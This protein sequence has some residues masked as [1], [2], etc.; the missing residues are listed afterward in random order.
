MNL[1]NPPWVTKDARPGMELAS[2]GGFGGPSEIALRGRAVLA[3]AGGMGFEQ[4]RRF[5]ASVEDYGLT[6]VQAEILALTAQGLTNFEVAKRRG[7]SEGT[8]KVH[9][10]RIFTKLKV[11]SRCEAIAFYLHLN[12]VGPEELR[13]AQSGHMD[14]KWLLA[15][16]THERHSKGTV[17]FRHGDVGD[18]IYYVQR[19]IVGLKEI[20]VEMEPHALFGEIGVFAPEHRRTCTAVC[21]TPVD[22]FTL[23]FEEVR[24]CYF[25]NPQFAFYVMYLITQ[26]L[27]ADRDRVRTGAR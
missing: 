20:D 9:M 14:M 27:I 4:P 13:R 19:G 2:G 7:S 22:L 3:S 17:L 11:R 26:R 24:R 1:T 25:L 6:Q 10:S 12:N 8:V 5:D 23:T 15:T 18:K 21:K 16:M